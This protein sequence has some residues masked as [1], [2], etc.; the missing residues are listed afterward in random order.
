MQGQ[1]LG[2]GVGKMR[3]WGGWGARLLGG[4]AAVAEVFGQ[5]EALKGEE[6]RLPLASARLSLL[7]FLPPLPPTARGLCPGPGSPSLPSDPR[8]PS[9]P[10]RASLRTPARQG[11]LVEAVGGPGR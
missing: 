6:T 5:D 11:R 7:P 3:L 8:A 9:P 4:D 10:H 1:A 2:P